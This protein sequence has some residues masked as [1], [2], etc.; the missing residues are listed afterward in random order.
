MESSKKDN[1]NK[2][3]KRKT[4]QTHP[5]NCTASQDNITFPCMMHVHTVHKED[6]VHTVR[7]VDTVCTVSIMDA[8]HTV[9]IMYA[10]HTVYI[11]DSVYSGYTFLFPHFPPVHYNKNN[12]YSSL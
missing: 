3:F 4:T 10:V 2:Y 7:I 8:F 9:Y 1:N 12:P 6:T 11:M 5:K